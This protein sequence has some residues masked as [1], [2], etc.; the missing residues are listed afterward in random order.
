[1]ISARTA[2]N[3]LTIEADANRPVRRRGRLFLLLAVPL[4]ALAVAAFISYSRSPYESYVSPRFG[5][6]AG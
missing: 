6:V 2:D 4:A 5:R 3:P 1:M